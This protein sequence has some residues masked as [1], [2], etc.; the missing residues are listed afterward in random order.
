MFSG[1]E[2][3]L[4]QVTQFGNGTFPAPMA[5]PNSRQ[6]AEIAALQDQVAEL[7]IG[8]EYAAKAGR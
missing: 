3:Q 5:D 2:R 1:R 6:D 8:R 7:R 4:V